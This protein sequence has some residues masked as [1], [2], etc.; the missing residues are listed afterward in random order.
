MGTLKSQQLFRFSIEGDRVIEQE[1]LLDD[2]A[3]VK[4]VEV[5]NEGEVYL[6]LE[7][8]EGSKVVRLAPELVEVD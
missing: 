4:D 1:I 6:L 2:L 8:A 5:G 7:S 3:R